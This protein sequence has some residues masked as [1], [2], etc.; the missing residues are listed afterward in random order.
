MSK[1]VDPF[2]DTGF[3]IIFGKE[4]KSNEI[5]KA[6]LNDLFE[7][8]PDFDP[9]EKLH[10]LNNERSR[11]SLEDRA[12]IY[13]IMCETQSGHRFIVEMQKQPQPYFFSRSVYYVSR[14]IYEQGLRGLRKEKDNWNY[15][16]IPVI[17]VFFCN[18]HVKELGNQLVQHIRLCDTATNK[19]A[20]N[21]MRYAFIQLPMFRKEEHECLT[22]FDKWIYILKNMS[23]MQTMPFTSHRDIFERLA[24]VSNVATLSPDE[25]QQYDYDIKKSRDYYAEMGYARD[26]A[27]QEGLAEGRAEGLV[28]G[29]AEGRAEE[30]RRI[31]RNM[32]QMGIDSKTITSATG[33]SES[34][35]ES[36]S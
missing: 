15:N 32:K 7:G 10:Y 6:F 29:R 35:L 30:M 14:A 4:N 8:Q 1:F 33:L 9:V 24:S 22:E 19:P 3:K 11:E 36:I 18:F 26:T 31:A 21:L 2:T 25:R 17:G 23:T 5:L 27:R 13:D 20:G 12:I 34:E 16:L 28:K